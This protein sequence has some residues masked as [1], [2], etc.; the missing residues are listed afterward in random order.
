MHRETARLHR[1]AKKLHWE[2]FVEGH[3][4]SRAEESQ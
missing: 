4:F 3:L 1:L 2:G